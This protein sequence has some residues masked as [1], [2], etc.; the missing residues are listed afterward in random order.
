M[1]K[2]HL[3][4]IAAVCVA[5]PAVL[6]GIP[7]YSGLV[8]YGAILALFG[9]SVN[10][11]VGYLGY[12]SFGH[13]AFFGLG[14]YTAGLLV[15]KLGF[16]FWVALFVAP[17]PAA[18]LGALVGFASARV[19]G[20]YFAIATLTTAE[21]L[22]LTAA[23]WVSLTRGPLGL[24]VPRP[25]IQ[26]L[27]SLGISFPQYYLFFCLALLAVTVLLIRRLVNSPVGRSWTTIRESSPLAES[28][29]MP[30]LRQRVLN[31]TLSGA[32]AGLAGALFVPRTLVLTPDLFNAVLSST[33]LLIAILGG[34]ATLIGPLLGG[35]T[36][37]VLPE[38][39]RFIDDYRIAIFAAILLLVVRLQPAGLVG[40]IPRLQRKPARMPVRTGDGPP[41]E[42]APFT[43][44]V[45]EALT[46][47]SLTKRFG[48]LTAVE[49]VSLEVRPGELLGIIGPNGAG[50][51]TCFSLMSGFLAPSEGRIAFGGMPVGAGSPHTMAGAGLV[52]T[53]QQTALTPDIT[54]YENA[55]AA[56]Y[57]SIPESFLASL[58][59]NAAYRKR[60]EERAELARRC[61]EFVGL[62]PRADDMA[63]SLPYGEQKMLSIASALAARPRMLLLDE[64][65]AGLNHAEA[66]QLLDLLSRL[67]DQGLTIAVIDHNLKMM[68]SLCDRMVVLDRGRMLASGKP[69]EVREDPAVITA[70]LGPGRKKET[71]DARANDL[72]DAPA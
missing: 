6:S 19:G 11:T 55:L 62:A 14:A 52:R 1:K 42:E 25:R 51:T 72:A 22:R 18:G 23:N 3:L 9:L 5:L 66:G 46:V 29:G 70:Y 8:T 17:L 32:L 53:F 68:M 69:A 2:T 60:E 27:E 47:E 7:Y 30:A 40:L 41:Q 59:Q 13:A 16:N 33:G 24:I 39:L 63:G 21:I 12:I 15:T 50:K 49:N 43:F 45:P 67:R 26:W 71:A 35:F 65:A 20:A 38:L 36:F 31:I 64:P 58:V 57:V 28:L 61:V 34:K 4:L 48:G 44:R 54:V 10:L 56:T 37:A